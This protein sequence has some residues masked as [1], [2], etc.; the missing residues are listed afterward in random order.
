MLAFNFFLSMDNFISYAHAL[1][2][3]FDD[4][5]FLNILIEDVVLF[6]NKYKFIDYYYYLYVQ[7]YW[8]YKFLKRIIM[9]MHFNALKFYI[10]FINDKTFFLIL[11]II[12]LFYY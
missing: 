3:I 8:V 9:F 12:Y 1:I 2:Y 11:I 4:S 10:I 6:Y 5:Q 7:L